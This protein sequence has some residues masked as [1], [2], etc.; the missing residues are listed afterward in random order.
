[1]KTQDVDANSDKS[2]D[3]TIQKVGLED[4]RCLLAFI[5]NDIKPRQKLIHDS[6]CRTVKFDD[7]WFLF[8]PGEPVITRNSRQAYRVIN[9]TCTRHRVQLF[10]K[11]NLK[12]LKDEPNAQFED[13]PIFI[14]CVYVDFDGVSIGPV[15]QNFTIS[16]FDGQKDVE[17][18]PI[19][20]LRFSRN[21]GLRESLIERGRR[22]IE[23][24]G[25][26]HM[27]YSGLSLKTHG[28]VDSQ[29]VI[30]FEEALTRN[31]KWKPEIESII[32]EDSKKRRTSSRSDSDTSSSSDSDLSP[33]P[34]YRP[35]PSF[36]R[37]RG[38]RVKARSCIAQCCANENTHHDDYVDTRR[39]EEYIGLQMNMKTPKMPSVAI[40][41]R[42]FNEL[43]GENILSDDE[44]LILSYRVFGFVMRS[45]KWGKCSTCYTV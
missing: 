28:D 26:K 42:L 1:M 31:P 19:Y 40:L 2:E 22:F 15:R 24:A 23:V 41:Q 43:T 29:V 8:N 6:L 44:L 9:T 34:R 35:Q 39:S 4:V 16:R 11:T 30:D 27:H 18:L 36:K 45:R 12:S 14:N 33:P 13:N 21:P 38:K 32:E 5:D 10:R 17:S 25:M 20:P 7:I 3:E 37:S